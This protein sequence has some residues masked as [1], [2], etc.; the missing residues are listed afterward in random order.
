MPPVSKRQR[1]MMDDFEHLNLEQGDRKPPAVRAPD[2]STT[3]ITSL[4]SD[5][6]DEAMSDK[7]QDEQE[8]TRKVMYNLALGT[9]TPQNPV[10]AKLDEMLR[11]TRLQLAL[12]KISKDDFDVETPYTHGSVMASDM[13]TRSRQRSNSLP[14]DWDGSMAQDDGAKDV[15]MML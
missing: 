15:D 10:D 14:R 11:Q 12:N 9:T 4:S 7:D 1:T 8:A 6:D 3:I 5:D 13:P 2:P